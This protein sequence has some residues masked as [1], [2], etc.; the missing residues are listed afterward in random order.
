MP[1]DDLVLKVE[2]VNKT[3]C[4]DSS[5]EECGVRAVKDLSFSVKRGERI[6]IMGKSGSGKSTLLHIIGCLDIPTSGKLFIDGTDTSQMSPSEL[7]DLRRD[8]VGF[9]FQQFHLIPTLTALQNVALPLML[10]GIPAKEREEKAKAVLESLGMGHRL[11]HLPS[12]LSGGEK[13]RVAIARALINEPPLILADEPTGNLDSKAGD[14]V[15]AVFEHLHKKEG[16]TI[17]VV[18]HDP[19]VAELSERIIQMKDGEIDEIRTVKRRR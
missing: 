3:Y 5:A 6:A 12:K 17:I 8:K 1:P 19:D 11:T 2:S 4:D 7:A 14:E 18:T 15:M 13:Q 16:K 9:V 10:K